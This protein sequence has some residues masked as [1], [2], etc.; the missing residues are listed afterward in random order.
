MIEERI[1]ALR[2]EMAQRG[3]DMYIVP[4]SD[5]HE[6]EYVGDYFKARKY[7][8]GFTGSAGTAV[9]TME[10]AGLWTDGRYFIQAE[11]QLAGTPVTLFKMQEEGV[12]TVEEYVQKNL[13]EGQCLGFDGRVMN[14]KAG[15]EYET[16]VKE[17]NGRLYVSEDLVGIIWTER[18]SLPAEPAFILAPEYAG[19]STQGKLTRLR[20]RMKEE[21]ATV[22]I[23]TS[24]YDIAWLLN[25]RGN[26]IAHVPVILSFVMVTENG[27]CW[28]VNDA[29]LNDELKTYLKV[30]SI[31]VKSYNDIYSDVE[32]LSAC[33]LY[34]SAYAFWH[35]R[36][37][38]CHN[39][40]QRESVDERQRIALHGRSKGH[41][42]LPG[43]GEA[44]CG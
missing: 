25:V 35:E 10:E 9:I 5:F 15:E 6:S 12:P 34:T 4:T 28:Y 21:G 17:K 33:L 36:E 14:G 44:A 32:C 18:P 42:R 26:D 29:V 16:I 20:E 23:L 19:E 27:C 7:I 22:H 40:D 38:D 1:K 41:G 13:K 37:Q 8:T 43:S 39:D 31:Q 3:I 30:N 24:L 2:R 11:N